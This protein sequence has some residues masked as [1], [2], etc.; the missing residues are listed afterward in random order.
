MSRARKIRK[1]RLQ[2][3][4][5]IPV[6][7]G[8]G[9]PPIWRPAKKGTKALVVGENCKTVI[10]MALQGYSTRTEGGKLECFK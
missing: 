2:G 3:L 9:L 4:L 10:D 1:D 7:L 5:L 8:D 6:I